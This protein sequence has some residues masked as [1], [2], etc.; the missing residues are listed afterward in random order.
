MS[1]DGDGQDVPGRRGCRGR[2]NSRQITA[3]GLADA[4]QSASLKWR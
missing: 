2:R 4:Q 1:G 3:A